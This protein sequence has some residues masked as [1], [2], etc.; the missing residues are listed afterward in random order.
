L[1]AAVRRIRADGVIIRTWRRRTVVFKASSRRTLVR[2]RAVSG[3]LR[4][5][6]VR[7]VVTGRRARILPIIA[8]HAA[9]TFAVSMCSRHF[10]GGRGA[11]GRH[12]RGR[13]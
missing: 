1:G 9:L 13:S 4:P 7:G 5:I 6:V 3:T 10:A 2:S 12:R 11:R 8:V